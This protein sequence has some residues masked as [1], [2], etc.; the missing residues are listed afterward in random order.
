MP[1]LVALFLLLGLAP[2]PAAAQ[3]LGTD[4]LGPKG[5]VAPE[6]REA[7]QKEVQKAREELREEIRAKAQDQAVAREDLATLPPIEETRKLNL[8]QISGA[9]RMRG[10]LFDD[11]SLKRSPDAAGFY[12]SPPPY[13]NA[14]RAT[15]TSANLRLRLEPTLNVSDQIRVLAQLDLL[16]N[17][18]LGTNPEKDQPVQPVPLAGTQAAQSDPVHVKRVWGE[19][20]TPVGLL[21]FGRMPS[22]WGLGILANAGAELDDDRG[23]SV[24]RLQLAIPLRQTPF[25]PLVIVPHYDVAASGIVSQGQNGSGQPFDLDKADDATALGLKVLRIDTDDELKRK[26]DRGDSSWNGGL[27]YS[28]RTQ[29]YE[30]AVNPG[31]STAGTA[32]DPTPGIPVPVNPIQV[33]R[34]V[35]AHVIDF[36]TRYRTKRLRLELEGAGIIGT[37]QDARLNPSDPA[38]GKVLLRQFGLAA[39]GDYRYLDGRL[40]LG[41]ELGLASGDRSP[42]MGNH[43]ERGLARPGSIDGNQAGTHFP[44]FDANGNDIGTDVLDNAIRNFRFNPAYRVDL[45][46]WR[47]LLG[48]VTDAWYL[49]PSLRYEVLD[50]LSLRAALVYSQAVYASSTPSTNHRPLGLEVDTG[51]H[52]VSGDGFHV[53]LDWGI[54]QPLDGLNYEPDRLS[55]TRHDLVRAHALRSGVAIRF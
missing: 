39:Q 28:Y 51:L 14:D 21:S 26:L 30:L 43:A 48:N 55:A 38:L 40:V 4:Q 32:P 13:G 49:K 12:L 19:V 33:K 46:L 3:A 15:Q 36:W 16:D 52:Y 35:S 34:G 54:L 37:I 42:G 24:D 47:E 6:V 23:D 53:W 44:V 1:R 50:G 11:L 8:L 45:I 18:V 27:W 7:I 29:S 31:D 9:L 5:E 41:L 20:Q 25:G 10:D 22:Q 17:V 2:L